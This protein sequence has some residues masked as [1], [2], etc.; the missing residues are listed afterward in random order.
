VITTLAFRLAERGDLGRVARR[1]A[2]G[3]QGAVA[4][5]GAALMA[6]FAE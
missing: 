1:G 5:T 4:L 2:V 6:E 3:G